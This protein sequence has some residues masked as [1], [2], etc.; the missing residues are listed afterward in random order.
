MFR[1]DYGYLSMYNKEVDSMTIY[2]LAETPSTGFC[3]PNMPESFY[4][5]QKK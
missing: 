2:R 5:L 3:V 4:K 1:T